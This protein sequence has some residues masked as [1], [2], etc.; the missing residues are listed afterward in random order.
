MKSKPRLAIACIALVLSLAAACA[1]GAGPSA[2]DRDPSKAELVVELSDFAPA[3]EIDPANLVMHRGRPIFLSGMNLAWIDFGKDLVNFRESKFT[4]AVEEIAFA[5]GNAIRWWIFVNASHSPQFGPDG[6]VSGISDE[7]V[8]AL[9][10]ALDIAYERGVGLIP[11]LLSFDIL[12]RYNGAVP[13]RNKLLVESEAATRAF[14]EK[15]VK[16]LLDKVKHHPGLIAWEVFN[17]PEG[18]TGFGWSAGR[19]TM[20]AVQAF[21]NRTAGFIHR[22]APGSKVTNGSWSFQVLTDRNGLMNYY[23]DDRLVAA[24]GDPDGTLDFYCVHYYPEHFDEDLSPFHHPK[25]YWGLDKPVVIAEFPSKGI[26]SYDGKI[27]VPEKQ[28]STEE[29]WRWAIEQGY[30]G[31]LSWTYSN[32]DGFGGLN[33][34]IDAIAS[35]ASLYGDYVQMDR[36]ELDRSPSLVKPI[37][38][39]ILSAAKREHPGFIDLGEHIQDQ[40]DGR[41][42][43]FSVAS[44]GDESVLVASVD[45]EGKLSVVLPEG[46]KPGSSKI[47]VNARDSYGNE[48]QVSFILHVVDPDRGNVA[49]LKPVKASSVEDEEK[50]PEHAVDGDP[51]T[52]WSS[53]YRDAQWL[54]IDL[55][56]EFL[57]QKAVINWEAAYG[58][59]YDVLGSMDGQEWFV[60]AERRGMKGK[61]DEFALEPRV[62]AYVKLDCRIRG[63]Q[64][65]FS[66]WEVEIHG[67]RVKAGE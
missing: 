57:M 24:G 11:C 62:A 16:P 18:M 34:S 40:E 32:H 35:V 45:G 21:V 33:D 3:A 36:S 43:A 30:A 15:A 58:A 29:A 53:E 6:M 27:C 44:Q 48:T 23:R 26:R 52:R 65:G 56:G 4:Q 13:E 9:K 60:L 54:V 39:V 25:S 7:E 63:T 1:G 10:R 31:A 64:W 41:R 2:V 28:L 46:A 8:M 38:R 12:Q 19:T 22:E 51:K 17:E 66:P 20:D 55:Q 5:G 47:A 49:L 14:L 67:E 37:E 61:I 59:D 50:P 42:L